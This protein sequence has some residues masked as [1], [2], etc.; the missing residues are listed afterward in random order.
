MVLK[1][2]SLFYVCLRT[3]PAYT[4]VRGMVSVADS[5]VI[6]LPLLVSLAKSA[7]TNMNGGITCT[8]FQAQPRPSSVTKCFVCSINPLLAEAGA[9]TCFKKYSVL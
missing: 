3:A 5:S 6:Q 1:S 9:L 8:A 2:C 7:A 4:Y